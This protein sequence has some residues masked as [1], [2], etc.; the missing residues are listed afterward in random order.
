M[1]DW[2]PLDI[3]WT[4]A[5]LWGPEPV[6][7]ENLVR[8]MS[9]WKCDLKKVRELRASESKRARRSRGRGIFVVS[10]TAISCRE[11]KQ[12]LDGTSILQWQSLF[13]GVI[14]EDG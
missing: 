3:G 13:G 1:K 9:R 12:G 11:E 4:R 5:L 6:C 10:C 2:D 8:I 7:F 14:V